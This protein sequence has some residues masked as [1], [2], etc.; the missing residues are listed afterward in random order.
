MTVDFAAAALAAQRA[1]AAYIEQASQSKAAFS[2]L[3]DAWIGMTSGV[4]YQAV[5]SADAAG[6]VH[7]TI[8]GTRASQ[9]ELV[10]VFDDMDLSPAQVAGGTVTAGVLHDQD[11]LWKWA[12]GEVDSKAVVN[13]AGHSLGAARTHL[14]PLF[15]PAD[16]VGALHSF[17]APKFA[18]VAYYASYATALADM[19]CVVNGK[20]GWASWPWFDVTKS[21]PQNDHVWLQDVGYQMIPGPKWPGGWNFD[22]HGVALVGQ[23]LEALAAAQMKLAAAQWPRGGA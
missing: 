21:R 20:D 11:K 14:T 6:A 13:V 9:F 16:R 18:D 22:D 5:L 19:V 2:A 1:N 4:D 17:E 8:S 12:L 7:L 23:R 15:L 10:D 3:G